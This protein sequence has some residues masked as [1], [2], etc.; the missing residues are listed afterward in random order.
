MKE[1]FNP[2]NLFATVLMQEPRPAAILLV[3]GDDE[4]T[5]LYNH[6]DQNVVA[7]INCGGKRN[8]LGVAAMSESH[9][10]DNV[11][12]LVDRDLDDLIG[13]SAYPAKVVATQNYDL[14]A[15]VLD[16]A[17]G[18][19][20]RAAHAHAPAAARRVESQGKSEIDSIVFEL[21]SRLAAVRLATRTVSAPLVLRGYDF[22]PVVD[23][24]FGPSGIERYLANARCTDPAFVIDK[25]FIGHVERASI[26]ID[27]H[28]RYSGGHDIVGASIATLS[29]ASGQVA[30]K[31]LAGSI[32][33]AVTCELL[34]QLVCIRILADAIWNGSKVQAFD[35]VIGGAGATPT[36]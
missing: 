14:L 29:Q 30:R 7:M 21:T 9:G 31:A 10:F 17:P 32:I 16:S 8:V 11:Y 3:E 4:D 15:D 35:C 24:N 26:L 25:V 36:E 20:R 22:R 13:A 19:L 23:R 1:Y 34:A 27:G 6:V 2:Q 5:I 28:R 12:G 18:L 33:T